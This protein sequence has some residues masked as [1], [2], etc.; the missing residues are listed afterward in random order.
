[1]VSMRCKYT[2]N[3]NRRHRHIVNDHFSALIQNNIPK[4]NVKLD[5][6]DNFISD[7]TLVQYWISIVLLFIQNQKSN[8]QIQCI[9][10]LIIKRLIH[11]SKKTASFARFVTAKNCVDDS[12][13]PKRAMI[14]TNLSNRAYQTKILP[15]MFLFGMYNVQGQLVSTS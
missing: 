3:T 1:M 9:V 5:V 2:E 14:Q 13:L 4:T 7:H 10:K 15:A 6:M 8:N 11:I 12:V